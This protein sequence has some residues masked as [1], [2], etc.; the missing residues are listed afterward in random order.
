MDFVL[1]Y[2]TVL[3]FVSLLVKKLRICWEL[4]VHIRMRDPTKRHD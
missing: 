2:Q 1:I 4:R 3:S